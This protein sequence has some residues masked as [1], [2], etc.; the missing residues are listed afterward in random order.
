MPP[1]PFQ[2]TTLRD[3]AR[4]MPTKVHAEYTAKKTLC[5]T[6][7]Q[8]KPLVLLTA[9]GLLPRD[10]LYAFSRETATA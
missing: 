6:T 2:L 10:L 5:A 9:H 1:G 3:R 8:K 4:H 7:N